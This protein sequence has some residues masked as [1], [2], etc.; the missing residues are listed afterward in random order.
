MCCIDK[1]PFFLMSIVLAVHESLEFNA[2]LLD[3]NTTFADF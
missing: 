2:C 3:E 1:D